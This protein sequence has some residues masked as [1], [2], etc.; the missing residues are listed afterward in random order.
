VATLSDREQEVLG[1]LGTGEPSA[2]L[3]RRLFV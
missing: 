2:E 1:L 3:A